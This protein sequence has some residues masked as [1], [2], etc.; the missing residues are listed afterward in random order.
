[1]FKFSNIKII[2]ISMF[3]PFLLGHNYVSA[4]IVFNK[5]DSPY[6]IDT[7]YIVDAGDTL[8]MEAGVQVILN[9][10]INILIFGI[11]FINGVPDDP[12]FLTPAIDSIGWG[13]IEIDSPGKEC[14]LENVYITDGRIITHDVSLVMQNVYFFNR[15]DL[16]WNDAITR[17]L[18]GNA[19]IIDSR[20]TGSGVG[21]GFLIHNQSNSIVSHCNFENIPDAIEFINVDNGIIRGNVFS[22]LPDDAIDL[23]NCSN[24]LIDSNIITNA[25]DRGMEIGSENFGSSDNIIIHRNLIIGCNEGVIFKENSFGLLQNNTFYKNNIAVSCIES[26]SVARGSSIIIENSIFSMS[27][28]AD[29]YFDN[30]STIDV[31]YSL[32]DMLLPNGTNNLFDDPL[33]V[34][35]EE[36]DFSLLDNS[37][38]INAGDPQSPLDPDYTVCDMGAYYYNSDTSTIYENEL[39]SI[40]AYPNPCMGKFYLKY[41]LLH[42]NTVSLVMFDIFGIKINEAT[43][44]DQFSGYHTIMI[45]LSDYNIAGPIVCRF[46]AGDYFKE[47]IMIKHD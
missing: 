45:D 32:S 30:A 19:V 16:A 34:N 12:V 27:V 2:C 22:D 37:P 42:E 5:F 39:Y 11:L 23:N 20:I 17:V 21:E 7:D 41:Y 24:I 47:F 3:I 1:M 38:C 18:G 28:D 29:F 4:A 9:E 35:P 10:N 26:Q 31:S 36:N 14:R 13:I 25:E 8:I 43:Y 6:V 33:F 46:F 40:I 15:Q 44:K